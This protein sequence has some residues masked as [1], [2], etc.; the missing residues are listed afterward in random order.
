MRWSENFASSSNALLT[1]NF[2]TSAAS[3]ET[4]TRKAKASERDRAV[5]VKVAGWILATRYK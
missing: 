4:G 3:V 5:I 1:R 2:S